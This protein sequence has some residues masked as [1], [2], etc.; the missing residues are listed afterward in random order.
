[1]SER[2]GFADETGRGAKSEVIRWFL[3]TGN[4]LSIAGGIVLAS[5]LTVL[6]LLWEFGA[7]T[8]QPDSPMYFLFSS[9]VT[10]DLTLL[11]VVLSI[12]QLVLSRELGTPGQL[13][14]RIEKAI[15]YRETVEGVTETAVSPKT[16]PNFMQFLHES[17]YPLIERIDKGT[18][19]LD[20]DQLERQVRSLSQSLRED[21][22]TVNQT[23]DQDSPDAFTVMA[24][25][26]ATNHATQ[27][28]SIAQIQAEHSEQLSDDMR[29]ALGS[30]SDVLRQIDVARRY[31]RTVFVQR[32]LAYLS[33]ILLY[34]GVPAIIGGGIALI[35]YNTALATPVP[36]LLLQGT[37]VAAFT[38]GIAPLAVLVPFIL[39]LAWV[40]QQTATIAP[41]TAK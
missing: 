8:L 28:H 35:L 30:V 32:E 16:L 24:A 37:V 34:V 26:I 31:F 4:R 6:V 39:R 15:E 20:D 40:A 41:F 17:I 14:K 9:V 25:V 18:D 13:Q 1:M 29:D 38:I 7:A 33:R 5:L 19:E 36:P 12:N 3:L 11:T 21:A 27:L 10:G 23:L 2:R 22:D